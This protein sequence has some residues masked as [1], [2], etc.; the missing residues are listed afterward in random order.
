MEK[1]AYRVGAAALI[2]ALL[3]S[4][5]VVPA[6]A[7]EGEITEGAYV[8]VDYYFDSGQGASVPKYPNYIDASNYEL[9]DSDPFNLPVH[10]STVRQWYTANLTPN[11][12]PAYAWAFSYLDQFYLNLPELTGHVSLYGNFGGVARLEYIAGQQPRGGTSSVSSGNGRLQVQVST[13]A[14]YRMLPDG[15]YTELKTN[16][17]QFRYSFD[18]DVFEPIR[19]LNIGFGDWE[20]TYAGPYF[21]AYGYASQASTFR[22]EANWLISSLRVLSTASSADTAKLESIADQIVAGNEAAAEFYGDIMQILNNIYQRE[23]VMSDALQL[24]A[25]NIVD[26]CNYLSKLT[27]DVQI[28]K[29]NV[30]AYM[31]YLSKISGYTQLTAQHAAA[32]K[33]EL[34]KFHQ[35]YID[36]MYLLQSTIMT[37]SD[38]IQ[39]KMEEIFN[40]LTAYLDAT[41]GSA[42]PDGIQDTIDGTQSAIDQVDSIESSFTGN[43]GDSFAQLGLDDFHLG[44]DTLAGVMFVSSWFSNIFNNLGEFATLITLSLYLGIVGLIAGMVSRTGGRARKPPSRGRAPRDYQRTYNEDPNTRTYKNHV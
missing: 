11:G 3:L 36:M 38:D 28:I 37:E 23:G 35:H 6:S 26:I 22:V 15:E 5:V 17:Y 40:L 39:A 8:N 42:V 25:D 18:Q 30:S 24:V 44:T 29:Q 12:I 32:M 7:A 2:G 21:V 31:S 43:L 20:D 13:P 9:L 16:S 14:G 1:S 41:F 33:D 34:A 4:L 10:G 27:S 19:N